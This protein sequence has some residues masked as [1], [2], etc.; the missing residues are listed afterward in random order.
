M[1]MWYSRWRFTYQELAER[2]PHHP[3]NVSLQ[4]LLPLQHCAASPLGKHAL[5][6]TVVDFF[7]VVVHVLDEQDVVVQHL[8]VFWIVCA[9]LT[10]RRS[11]CTTTRSTGSGRFFGDDFEAVEHAAV[12]S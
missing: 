8:L 11:V 6:S 5:A 3:P 9:A 10:S 1:C 12:D 7:D 4:G 2:S